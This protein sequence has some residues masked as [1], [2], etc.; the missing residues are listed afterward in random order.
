MAHIHFFPF[1]SLFI[2]FFI[3]YK[4]FVWKHS[5]KGFNHIFSE[6]FTPIND[7]VFFSLH[8]NSNWPV[9]MHSLWVRQPHS[10]ICAP[11]GL[12]V[13]CCSLKRQVEIQIQKERKDR[14]LWER[15][16]APAHR[17]AL[18]VFL[19]IFPQEYS[20]EGLCWRLWIAPGQGGHAGSF[21]HISH[22]IT[23]NRVSVTALT[24]NIG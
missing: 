19:S 14:C 23:Q 6:I 9:F 17:G 11:R 21:C 15:G 16:P 3:S 7:T 13:C 24:K 8:F 5:P 22:H 1:L 20:T 12:R 10:G 18:W 2:Y 4:M